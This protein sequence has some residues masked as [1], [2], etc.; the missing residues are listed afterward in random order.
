MRIDQTRKLHAAGILP[1][2][3][4]TEDVDALRQRLSALRLVFAAEALGDLLTD[5]VKTQATSASFLDALLR[6]ELERQEGATDCPVDTHLAFTGW[7]N[8]YEFR[9]RVPTIGLA[10]PD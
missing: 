7:P 1:S 10:K 5:A 4:P 2:P 9:F 8:D 6:L 3:A